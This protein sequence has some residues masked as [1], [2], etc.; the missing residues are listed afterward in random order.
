M[1]QVMAAPVGP[2]RPAPVRHVPRARR[3][4]TLL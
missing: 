2:A 1:N 3:A 4:A